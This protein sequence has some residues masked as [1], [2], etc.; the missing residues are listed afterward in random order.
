MFLLPRG[1]FGPK[2]KENIAQGLPWVLGL[3][4]EALKHSTRC[5]LLIPGGRPLTRYPGVASRNAG[6]PLQGFVTLERV[7]QGK[8]WAMFSWPF[9]PSRFAA[10][11]G[12]YLQRRSQRDGGKWYSDRKTAE[13]D[14]EEDEKDSKRPVEREIRTENHKRERELKMGGSW[15]F[16]GEKEVLCEEKQT[17][18]VA[19]DKLSSRLDISGSEQ[20]GFK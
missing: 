5:R 7:L 4:P 16:F 9:G 3:S 15:N 19:F 20:S 14:D 17:K 11:R 12:G 2:G 1:G 8:P 13:D 6:L 18:D 10:I